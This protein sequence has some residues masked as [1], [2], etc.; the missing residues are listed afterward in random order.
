MQLTQT[1]VPCQLRQAGYVSI[2]VSLFV[3][4]HD[5][6]KYTQPIFTEFGGKMAHGPRKKQIEFGGN[7][8]HVTSGIG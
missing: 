7:P 5:N 6:V 1:Y 4:Q 3:C 8:N 2:G